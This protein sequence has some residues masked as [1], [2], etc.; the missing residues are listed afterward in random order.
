MA[1][2]ALHHDSIDLPSGDALEK[3]LERRPIHRGAARSDVVEALLQ[4]D[5]AV[6]RVRADAREAS[7]PLGIAGSEVGAVRVGDRLARVNGAPSVAALDLAKLSGPS[8]AADP[9]DLY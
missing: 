5:P 2:E 7:V 6:K 4:G 9:N 8:C 3:P 1:I